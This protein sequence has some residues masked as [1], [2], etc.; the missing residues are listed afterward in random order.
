MI[1]TV[2]ARLKRPEKGWDPVPAQH[3]AKYAGH[4]TDAATVETVDSL[5]DRVGSLE[6]RR[7]LDLGGGPGHFTVELARRGAIV[8]WHDISDR[9]RAMCRERARA[10][11]VQ[12]E[13]S[14]GYLEEARRLAPG[15][16]D[17]VFNRV[18]WC[19]CANDA[20]FASI[21]YGLV[22]PG[23]W[24][25]V[26]SNTSRWEEPSGWWRRTQYWMQRRLGLK[27]GH[28]HPEPGAVASLLLAHG[29][30]ELQ[31]ISTAGGRYDT[32]VFRR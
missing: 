25:Y 15:S 8:T 22:R 21:L 29:P 27:V 13:F 19:Y 20:Q 11:G 28:P 31:L 12:I 1:N 30:S 9:Y 18:C 23:G 10:A 3:A 5:E 24:G 17:V 14:L 32:V 16:F 7:V 4:I 2:H 6:G 26:E